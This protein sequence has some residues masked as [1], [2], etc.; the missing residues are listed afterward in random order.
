[1]SNERLKKHSPPLL[2]WR[3]D[4]AHPELSWCKRAA[5]SGKGAEQQERLKHIENAMQQGG[6]LPVVLAVIGSF[7][8]VGFIIQLA[9]GGRVGA[10]HR[11]RFG[12]CHRR[13]VAARQDYEV[14]ALLAVLR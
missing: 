1:M 12:D 2:E 14:R 13:Y 5:R 3:V 8:F 11:R 10:L 9:S 6:N 4:F 7:L